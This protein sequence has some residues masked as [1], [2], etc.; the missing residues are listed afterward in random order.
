[1]SKLDFIGQPLLINKKSGKIMKENV[2]LL[3]QMP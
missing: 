2:L 1:M 3:P